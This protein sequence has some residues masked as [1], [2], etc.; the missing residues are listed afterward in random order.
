MV[1]W[2]QM[3]HIAGTVER[4]RGL[5]GSRLILIGGFGGLL[6]LM[7]FAGL[8]TL[9][10]FRY[11]AQ[12]NETIRRGFLVR[13]RLL[14]EIRA[15]LYVSGTYV[16]DYLLESDI[17]L[18]TKH[19]ASLEKAR[20]DMDAAL[21]QYT[22]LTN[23][24]E[25][26]PFNDLKR[27]LSGYWALLQP[28]TRWNAEERRAHG[29][30]F[31]RDEVFP[32]RTVMLGLADQ[33]ARVNERQLDAAGAET[34]ALFSSF[35]LRLGLTLS[36]SLTVGVLL[37]LF[38]TRKALRLEQESGVRFQEIA[39][40]RAQLK[41]LSAK[42]VAAQEAERRLIARELH[43]EVGQALSGLRVGLSNLAASLPPT[44][45]SETKSQMDG[46]R[47]LAETAMG[48]VRNIT[49]LLRPSMLDDLGLVPALQWQGREVSK[50]TG[51]NVKVAAHG[52]SE[53][54]PEAYKTC[55]YRVVQ[56]ALNNC[57]RHAAAESARVTVRQES[58]RLLL[59]IE[60]DGKGFRPELERGLGLL[61]MEERV[62]H[63]R[64]TFEVKSQAGLGTLIA[65]VLPL[66]A[67]AAEGAEAAGG[68]ADA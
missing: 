36:I 21:L 28:V 31:L 49:L 4:L 52:V 50:R 20:R 3:S 58:N 51:L 9:R 42:L 16:R 7:A 53:D 63:L 67:E 5:P 24:D 12:R 14:N 43:D 22:S 6:F 11:V 59:S 54:L 10:V 38:S 23:P 37:A 56:E 60:D 41:E 27:E 35:A 39:S 66:R 68:A 44:I 57:A 30:P 26:A 25:T 46:L 64:G 17:G 34:A 45:S 1:D 13:D 19:R 62:T 15:D 8:D 33:I 61:G 2:R 55:V 18:A 29:Y 65:I 40:A 48:V 47:S 32:R